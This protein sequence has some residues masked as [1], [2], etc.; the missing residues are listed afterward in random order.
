MTTK[1]LKLSVQKSAA[2]KQHRENRADGALKENFRK[3]SAEMKKQVRI[4]KTKYVL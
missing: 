3:I 4:E 2:Y 1:L